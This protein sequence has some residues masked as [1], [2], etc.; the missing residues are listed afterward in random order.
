ME[1]S[2]PESRRNFAVIA[3]NIDNRP[4]DEVKKH[5]MGFYVIGGEGVN[6]RALSTVWFYHIK[7]KMW[8]KVC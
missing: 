7:R 5:E 1:T 2:L 8:V 3:I 4:C 6:G